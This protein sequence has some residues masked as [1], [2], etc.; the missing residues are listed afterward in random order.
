MQHARIAPLAT[1]RRD[2]ARASIIAAFLALVSVGAA[3]AEEK[4]G[5]KAETSLNF[6]AATTMETKAKLIE[7]VTIPF[8]AGGGSLTSGNN[9][10]LKAA[11]ELSPVSVNG[12]LEARLTPIAFL[13]FVAGG[14]VGSGWNIPIANGLRYNRELNARDRE[15]VGGPLSGVVWSAKGGGLFQFD[16][17]AISP[18]DWHHVVFQTYHAA[19]YRALTSASPEESWLYEADSGE[20]RNGWSYYGNYFLG[21]QMPIVLNTAGILV[22]EDLYLFPTPSRDLWGD[23]IPRWTFGPMLNFA[24]TKNFSAA[25]LAQCR[26]VRNFTAQTEGYGFYQA[27]RLDDDELRV[28]FYRAALN[29]TVKL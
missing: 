8:L 7:T 29:V 6:V 28:E 15:L 14:S 13:Q 17:A 19:Q 9:V 21:Y 16:L 25:I 10:Q 27:R 12:T 1:K 18:G 24:V 2:S 26:T 3:F 5:I 4:T 11:A 20:N 22:E 23:D